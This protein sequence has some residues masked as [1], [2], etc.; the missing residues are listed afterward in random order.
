MNECKRELNWWEHYPLHKLWCND[1]LPIIPRFSYRPKDEYNAN[2][3]SVHWLIFHLWTL[4]HVSLQVDA[5]LSPSRIGIGI[6]IP[7]LRVWIGFAHMY[8]PISSFFYKY[9]T[10]KGTLDQ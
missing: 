1:L 5:E 3:V 2:D 9:L 6:I 4:S 10:R 8:G 7:Y